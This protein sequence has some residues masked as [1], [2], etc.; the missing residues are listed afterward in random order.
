MPAKKVDFDT[1]RKIGLALPGVEESASFGAFALKAGG[2]MF[3]CVPTNK[4]AEPG[5]LLI[6]VDLDR[7]AEM[8]EADPETYYITGHYADYPS[9]LVRLA[10]VDEG[11][12]RDLLG[13]AHGVVLRKKALRKKS[14]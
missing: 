13:M 2:K 9:V 11:V 1:V 14:K 10:R 4:S 3:A 7:R 12:L 5:S 6:R 8:L